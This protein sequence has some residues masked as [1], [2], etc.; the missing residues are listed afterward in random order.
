MSALADAPVIDASGATREVD[1]VRR[2]VEVL[3]IGGLIG[4]PTETVYGLGA[5]ASNAAAVARIFAAKQRP[6][7][8]PLIVHMHRAS[9][10]GAWARHVPKVAWQLAEAFWPGPLTLILPRA[11]GV[12]DAVT[13][14]LDTIALR[15]P[16]HSLALQ[17][18]EQFGG[19]VAAPSANRHKAISPTSMQD[20]RDDLGDAVDLLLDGGDCS[21]G[22]ESTIV[23]LST[24]S[25]RVLRPGAI[26]AAALM[27]VTGFSVEADVD[28]APRCPG[29]TD[30][31]YAPQ[32]RVVIA[33]MEQV[34]PEINACLARGASVGVLAALR[35]PTWPEQ[36]PWLPLG[37]SQTEQAQQLYRR[38]READRIGL[39]VLIAV[40]PINLGLGHALRDRL[41]RAA[42]LGASL[43]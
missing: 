16:A 26:T 18:L 9:Q 37:D 35:S 25:L 32:A 10:L 21:V 17:V 41:W 2:A 8:H 34:L 15:V 30:T 11:A 27:R 43:R 23:D 4:L 6:A 19:G 5:D 28:C 39:D 14:G 3:R 24:D 12:L 36:I 22:I 20:V 42:G 33:A 13:G 38:L 7:D 40:A 1:D 31:H 29:R